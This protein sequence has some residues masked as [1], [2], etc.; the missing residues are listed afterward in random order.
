M[1]NNYVSFF[2]NA[3]SGTFTKFTGVKVSQYKSAQPVLN[4]L[5]LCR[6]VSG[7]ARGNVRLPIQLHN[8]SDSPRFFSVSVWQGDSQMRGEYN[9]SQWLGYL[10]QAALQRQ[11]TAGP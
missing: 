6:S 11:L 10:L 4:T 1:L 2:L 7:V 8:S 3:F 5:I 9:Y